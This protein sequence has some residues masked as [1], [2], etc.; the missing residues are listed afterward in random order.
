MSLCFCDSSF[1]KILQQWESRNSQGQIY[2]RYSLLR[3]SPKLPKVRW[4]IRPPDV[5]PP[6]LLYLHG[7]RGFSR[8]D[9]NIHWATANWRPKSV[10]LLA[11]Q[12]RHVPLRDSRGLRQIENKIELCRAGEPSYLLGSPQSATRNSVCRKQRESQ[13]RHFDLE[14]EDRKLFKIL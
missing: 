2:T 7:T 10:L 13:K 12:R 1:C 14:E 4:H 6:F 3:L 5:T 8:E 11:E 9:G